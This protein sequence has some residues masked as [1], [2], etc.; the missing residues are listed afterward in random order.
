MSDWASSSII[1]DVELIRQMF[2]LLYRQYGALDEV[3][4]SSENT[5]TNENLIFEN[6][7]SFHRLRQLRQ[8]LTRTYAIGNRSKEDVSR[9]LRSL[10]RIR[11]L[12]GVQVG[13]NEEIL[14]KNC[15]WYVL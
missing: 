8:G 1:E 10:G 6:K 15:L 4:G 12:L 11:C 3:S 14:L 9:L 13:A 5:T 7:L 2:Y